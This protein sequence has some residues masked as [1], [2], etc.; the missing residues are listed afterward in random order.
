M[1]E[2]ENFDAC[3]EVCSHC[4]VIDLCLKYAIANDEKYFVWGGMTPAERTR[5]KKSVDVS[6]VPL[7][8]RDHYLKVEGRV[9]RGNASPTPKPVR[10]PAL[11]YVID[12]EFLELIDAL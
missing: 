2:K 11:D 10:N 4:P 7:E 5:F 12:P 9:K 3:K 6:R 1:E 8:F